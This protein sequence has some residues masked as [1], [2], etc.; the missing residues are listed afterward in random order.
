M[1]G[2]WGLP[3]LPSI[4]DVADY[5]TPIA[6]NAPRDYPLGIEDDAEGF[7]DGRTFDEVADRFA[8]NLL[9]ICSMGSHKY[10]SIAICGHWGSGKTSFVHRVVE[11]FDRHGRVVFF[12]PWMFSSEKSLIDQFF[13]QLSSAL[14]SED[15]PLMGDYARAVIDLVGSGV[16]DYAIG[17]D[18]RGIGSGIANAIK[19]VS[20]VS[21]AGSSNSLEGE[22]LVKTKARIEQKLDEIDEPIIV[23][24]DNVDRLTPNLMV[25]L[26]QFMGSV[27]NFPNMLYLALFD[28]NV[29]TAALERELKLPEG[30]GD[31]FLAKVVYLCISLPQ[32]KLDGLV[33]R[34]FR[35]E[36]EFTSVQDGVTKRYKQNQVEL[37]KLIAFILGDARSVLKAS[38]SYLATN[39]IGGGGQ[40]IATAPISDVVMC[41]KLPAYYSALRACGKERVSRFIRTME[42]TR[43]S[44]VAENTLGEEASNLTS[45]GDP[46]QED[47]YKQSPNSE[48]AA[49]IYITDAVS[50]KNYQAEQAAQ[51]S[52]TLGALL[53]MFV[54]LLPCKPDAERLKQL[55]EDYWSGRGL[56]VELNDGD[57][58]TR[59]AMLLWCSLTASSLEQQIRET[60]RLHAE[61]AAIVRPVRI[62]YR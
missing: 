54:S 60:M 46:G 32:V 19:S 12:D 50:E 26:F 57:V 62:P 61:D 51:Q 52:M 21:S 48:N 45:K 14:G 35:F 53:E 30:E 59:D 42:A 39:L 18:Y 13:R 9:G 37:A 49:M 34:Q 1:L 36:S 20:Q 5:A 3:M 15:R 22:A 31:A 56:P 38:Q 10:R 27:A 23:V 17:K 58:V 41:S 24:I 44:F 11:R 16:F 28:R 55:V 2:E 6:K 4:D 40:L 33:E 8:D 47:V 25:L 43:R 29:V 7:I